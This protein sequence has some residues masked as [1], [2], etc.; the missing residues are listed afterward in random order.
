MSIE[1][2]RSSRINSRQVLPQSASLCSVHFLVPFENVGLASEISGCS[3]HRPKVFSVAPE[4]CS[5]LEKR[6]P[7]TPQLPIVREVRNAIR[8][9]SETYRL[10]G[11][12]NV[13]VHNFNFLAPSPPHND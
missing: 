1:F 9:S 7:L 4:R 13:N 3:Q 12:F 5:L 2:N 10:I 6:P 8:S 11:W